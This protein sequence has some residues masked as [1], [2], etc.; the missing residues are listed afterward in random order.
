MY[1]TTILNYSFLF[2][3]IKPLLKAVIEG[4][5]HFLTPCILEDHNLHLLISP[6]PKPSHFHINNLIKELRLHANQLATTT[7]K[8]KVD[9]SILE[10]S[11]AYFPECTFTFNM[12]EN[13]RCCQNSLMVVAR[14]RSSGATSVWLVSGI[15]SGVAFITILE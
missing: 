14:V 13:V 1:Y 8:G 12:A 15:Q 2:E 4:K 3:W 5:N 6:T 10:C 11:V 9:L 7:E